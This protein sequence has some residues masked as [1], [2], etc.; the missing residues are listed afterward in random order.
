M[1]HV[2]DQAC[3]DVGRTA[4]TARAASA[5]TRALARV[6]LGRMA[7]G[8]QSAQRRQAR[9]LQRTNQ[10]VKFTNQADLSNIQ[11]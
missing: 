6:K 5:P 7:A 2:L 1:T 11:L 10:P 8:K 3:D 4:T 9:Q